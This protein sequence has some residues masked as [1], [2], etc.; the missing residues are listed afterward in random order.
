MKIFTYTRISSIL[1]KES[2]PCHLSQKALSN[3]RFSFLSIFFLFLFIALIT[4]EAKGAN[5]LFSED[6]ETGML[7]NTI[8]SSSGG[9]THNISA[10]LLNPERSENS[11][12]AA[13]VVYSG[14]NNLQ[15]LICI[16]PPYSTQELYIK[17]YY[18]H[19]EDFDIHHNH[20]MGRLIENDDTYPAQQME[21]QRFNGSDYKV[22]GMGAIVNKWHSGPSF[23]GAWHKYEIFLKY[24]SSADESDGTIKVWIDG[25]LRVDLDANAKFI[26]E[27]PVADHIFRKIYLPGNFADK[28]TGDDTYQVD[29]IEIWDGMPLTDLT[30]TGLIIQP[31]F[32][33]TE[34]FDDGDVSDWNDHYT[35]ILLIDSKKTHNGSS[36]SV[37]LNHIL[38]SSNPGNL[39]LFFADNPTSS[40]THTSPRLDE[41]FVQ[42]FVLFSSVTSWP[43]ISTKISKLESWPVAWA[44]N[45]NKN[46]YLTT[47]INSSGQFISTVN[48]IKDNIGY[49]S[50]IQNQGTPVSVVPNKWHKIKIRVKVNTPGAENGVIQMWIDDVLTTSYEDIVFCT[51]D[52]GYGWNNFA[53]GGYDNSFSPDIKQQYWD[54]ILISPTNIE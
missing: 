43:S 45:T 6:F 25:V 39:A 22:Q 23:D 4:T 28:P 27:N 30:P 34:N 48:R 42:Y 14:T 36:Y 12:W 7:R 41:V 40:N 15:H 5:L 54:D 32:Y 33:F 44:N 26:T 13:E 9:D 29:D 17:Y 51:T 19:K 50:Y 38:D 24:N 11:K 8:P 46:F 31:V 47:E 35:N 37:H 20:K 49:I 1:V 52:A 53:L 3:T 18:R 10:I 16:I 2:K 21:L